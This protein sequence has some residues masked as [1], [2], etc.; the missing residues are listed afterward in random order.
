MSSTTAA[1]AASSKNAEAFKPLLF[2]QHQ[3]E[4]VIILSELIIP[5][6]DTPGAKA[7][8]VNEFID[9]VLHD[10]KPERR[11]QFLQGLGWLDGFA[12]REHGKPFSN[13]TQA[14]QIALLE[15]LDQ[16]PG[17][18]APPELEDGAAF[19]AEVKRLTVSGYYTS[20]IGIKELNKSGNVPASFG[21][22]HGGKH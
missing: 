16:K 13:C 18:A 4:T 2:D 19:F 17:V 6:T 7:A 21:C 1:K 11:N 3:N 9:L 10:G 12:M 5:A 22:T 14:Q 8:K 15:R 20:E